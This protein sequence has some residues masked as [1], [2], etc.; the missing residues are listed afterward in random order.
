[1]LDTRYIPVVVVV[2]VEEERGR[3]KVV[4][5]EGT[6]NPSSALESGSAFV[7]AVVHPQQYY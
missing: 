4:Q 6:N 2:V 1:M 5:I 7:V 3:N